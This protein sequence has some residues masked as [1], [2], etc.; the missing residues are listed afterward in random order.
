MIINSERDVEAH[1]LNGLTK[2]IIAKLDDGRRDANRKLVHNFESLCL[3][4]CRSVGRWR[5]FIHS[6]Q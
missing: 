4:V 2:D 1:L 3:T 5:H 6:P